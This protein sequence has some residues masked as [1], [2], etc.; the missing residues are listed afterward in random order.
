MKDHVPTT[1]LRSLAVRTAAALFR[2]SFKHRKDPAMIDLLFAWSWDGHGR[3]T[4]L[5]LAAAISQLV[6][7]GKSDLMKRIY[8]LFQ[9]SIQDVA[10]EYGSPTSHLY[11]DL[12]K[13]PVP[14]TDQSRSALNSLFSSLPGRVQTADIHLGNIPWG[15][16]EFL[17][18]NGQ[19]RHFMRSTE[20]T[21]AIDAYA[22]SMG[23]I[24]NH[25]TDARRQLENAL[26]K[27]YS[28]FT[29]SGNIGDFYGGLGNLAE[30][31]HT[32]EDS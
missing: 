13:A 11:K 20:K 15:I 26:Y 1:D 25:L 31:L 22:N 6:R 21:S 30:G 19:V 28:F 18:S 14:S 9:E 32:V 17:D 12:D 8:R 3:L 27:D 7:L 24:R 5:A 16:G 29:L 23:W 2:L 4:A 10:Q